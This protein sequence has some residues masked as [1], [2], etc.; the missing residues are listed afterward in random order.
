MH[1]GISRKPSKRDQLFCKKALVTADTDKLNLGACDPMETIGEE[2]IATVISASNENVLA[3][4]LNRQSSRLTDCQNGCSAI[5]YARNIDKSLVSLLA[6]S[7]VKRVIEQI[8]NNEIS[9]NEFLKG[10]GEVVD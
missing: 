3:L 2:I 7:H 8:I 4:G 6:C 5:N 9:V 1:E 10:E